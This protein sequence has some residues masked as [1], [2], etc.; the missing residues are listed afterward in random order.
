M[1]ML[2]L[3]P[4]R[5]DLWSLTGLT[6][7][8]YFILEGIVYYSERE[9]KLHRGYNGELD[10]DVYR[11]DIFNMGYGERDIIYFFNNMVKNGGRNLG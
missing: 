1:E 11:T 5:I 2:W 9:G 6:L 7:K 10:L 4:I 8:D 3:E